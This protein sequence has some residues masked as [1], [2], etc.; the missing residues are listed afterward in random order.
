MSAFDSLPSVTLAIPTLNE[1]KNI[2]GCLESI[3][4][5]DY[6]R[7][8]VEVLIADGFS[9]DRTR[10]IA[11]EF[12]VSLIDNPSTDT[13]IGK[14]LC[15]HQAK[16][17]L[18]YYLDADIRLRGSEWIKKMVYP[19][20]QEKEIVASFTRKFSPP[21][22]CAFN[23]Y[24]TYHPLQADPINEYFM[25]PIER[26]VVYRTKGYGVCD[27]QVGKIPP[28][29]RC[30]FRREVLYSLIKDHK[31]FLELDNLVICSAAGYTKFAYVPDAGI[32]H[33]HAKNLWQLVRKRLRN[34]NTSFLP[35]LES[36][37]FTWINLK[38]LGGWLKVILW[39]IYANLFF[40]AAI[41]GIYKAIRYRDIACLY[42][43]LTALI[44]TDAI[45]LNL[46]KRKSFL[47]FLRVLRGRK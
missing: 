14:M 26:T 38:T 10:A 35:E 20:V 15:L 43:P 27:Y 24:L 23:R 7:E 19:L 42:E 37:Q 31:K 5:Q 39:V 30:M 1:E 46:L 9:R 28:S 11:K 16:N 13:E 17:E 3:F 22:D 29:G 4:S 41:R 36:R 12:P 2:R 32:Y 47:K 6:P 18:F 45:I 40:P 21:E 8:K 44:L 25:V 34:L 33:L